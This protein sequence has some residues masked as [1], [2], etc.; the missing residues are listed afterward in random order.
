MSR[1]L[2]NLIRQAGVVFRR[3][4]KEGKFDEELQKLK[5]MVSPMSGSVLTKNRLS[6]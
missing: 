2:A 3:S 6:T 4:K 5:D 1:N